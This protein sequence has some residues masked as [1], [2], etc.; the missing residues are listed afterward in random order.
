LGFIWAATEMVRMAICKNTA[1]TK[2]FI[3]IFTLR[4]ER[5]QFLIQPVV[6]AENHAPV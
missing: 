5:G 4:I 3:V 2:F 6:R 1:K